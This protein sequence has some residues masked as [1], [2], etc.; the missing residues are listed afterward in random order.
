[1]FGAF[2]AWFGFNIVWWEGSPTGEP[3]P[4]GDGS[5]VSILD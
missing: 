3:Q 2:L 1:M 5:V 4:Q